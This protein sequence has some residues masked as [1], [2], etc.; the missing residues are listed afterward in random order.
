ML[1]THFRA[2]LRGIE[3]M[4]FDKNYPNRK[5]IR[6]PYRKSKTICTACRNHGECE[7]CKGNRL[8]NRKLKEQI[9]REKLEE[10]RDEI[11]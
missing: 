3:E 11:N 1:K 2:S 7:W 10:Y 8:Y 9:A 6:K 5:D 4:S